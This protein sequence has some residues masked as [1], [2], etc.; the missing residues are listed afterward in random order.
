MLSRKEKILLP[1]GITALT[2]SFV[3]A[4]FAS[5]RFSSFKKSSGLDHYTLTLDSSK[6]PSTLTNE[7]QDSVSG[8]FT[9]ADG[10]SINLNFIKAKSANS[11]LVQ[12]ASRGM[13]F[14]YASEN[15]GISGISAITVNYT[16]STMS[17]RTSLSNA[18]SSGTSLTNLYT[19]SNNTRLELPSPRYFS[20]LAADDGNT[21]TS[22]TIE[23]SCEFNSDVSRLNG[24]YTGSGNDGYTYSLTLNNGSATFT[25]LDRQDAVSATGTATLND[26]SLQCSFTSPSAFNGLTYNFTSDNQSHS[27]TYVSKSGTGNANAPQ[28]NLYRV[29]KFEDFESYSSGGNGWDNSSGATKYTATGL[30]GDYVCEYVNSSA[31]SG[32]IGG[33]GWSLMGS[34]DYIVYNAN[35]GRNNSKTLALK[36]NN[37]QMRFF[38][39]SG[40][41]GIPTVIGKGN[42]L[43][44]W[45]KGAYSDSSLTTESTYCSNIK[46]YAFYTQKVGASTLTQRTEQDFVIASSNE[47]QEY[48]MDLDPTKTYYSIGF[49]DKNKDSATR[50]LPL[51]DF[52]IY[53]ESPYGKDLTETHSGNFKGQATRRNQSAY[54]VLAFLGSHNQVN[55]RVAGTKYDANY[56]CSGNSVTISTSENYIG[57]LTGTYDPTNNTINNCS[58]SGTIKNEINNNGNITLSELEHTWHCDEDSI[59]LRSVFKRRYMSG[60]WAFDNDNDDRIVSINYASISHNR[61]VRRRGYSGGAVSLV[62][63]ND[64]SSPATVQNICFWVYNPS[65]SDIQLRNWV[66][67]AA[68]LGSNVEVTGNVPAAAHQWT[69]LSIG[70]TQAEIYNFQLAD[71]TNS[72]VALAYDNISIY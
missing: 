60:S 32:P 28:I 44:F 45:S 52:S 3:V 58:F 34:N 20:L 37:N 38:Q 10:N 11:G 49:Y 17:L 30:K 50:Y 61:A 9:T 67:K 46:V 12:L 56:T 63:A 40:Y 59:G 29:Y 33:Q 21:I 55:F 14:N 53:T 62:L 7:Y 2:L 41:Y 23:Y 22:M 24:Q 19:I 42:K 36:G 47:W 6:A 15:G 13:L 48:V 35:K 66:Y 72:G 4:G 26:N 43:S 25:S 64:L 65:D 16:G 27:L 70:F 1:I 71:F 5:N 68:N 31:S 69:F 51:D 54:T 39:A 8:N 18:L 57:N